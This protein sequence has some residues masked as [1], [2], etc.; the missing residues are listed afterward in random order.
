MQDTGEARQM[1]TGVLAR[2]IARIV[3]HSRR[4]RVAAEGPVVAGIDPTSTGVGLA[5]GEHR[6]GRVV[7][8]QA[9]GGQ[10]MGLE[11][12]ED[13]PQNVDAGADL[14]CERRQAQRDAFPGV[15]LGLAVQWLMLAKLLE[16]DHRQKAGAGP[17]ARDDMERRRRLGRRSRNRGRR[18]SRARSG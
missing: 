11:A 13:R 9:L 16:H 2:S 3:K 8:V 4:R 5:L 18:T 12:F 17:A 6:H 15:A 7:A 10:D 1:A 14:V